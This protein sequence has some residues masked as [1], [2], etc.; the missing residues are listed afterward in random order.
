MCKEC[1]QSFCDTFCPNFS[2]YVAGVG[3]PHTACSSCGSFIYRGDVYYV[4][5]NRAYCE[6]CAKSFDISELADIF[7]FSKISDIIEGLGGELRQD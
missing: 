7:G 6:E 1:R 4:V 3:F 2:G 5:A